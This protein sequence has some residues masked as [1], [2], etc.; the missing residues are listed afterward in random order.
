MHPTVK[1]VALVAD[2][3]RDCS[4]RGEI[5]LDIFG[6][7]GT[8]LIAAESCG[9]QARL[10]EYDPTYCDTILTR[11]QAYTGKRASHAGDGRAFEDVA[12]E[13]RLAPVRS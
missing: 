5:V 12:A 6:G 1:P 3:I 11:W 10:L 8:T 7:S 2:A 9:R 4:R 13:R